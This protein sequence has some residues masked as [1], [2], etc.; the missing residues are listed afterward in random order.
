M[1]NP[2]YE[3]KKRERLSWP[4]LQLL[5]GMPLSTLRWLAARPTP[6]S[7]ARMTF[8]MHLRLKATTGVDFMKWFQDN[9]TVIITTPEET[10]ADLYRGL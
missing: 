3:Y 5:A 9:V 4:Q 8:G 6:S 1:I 2:L 10:E 7:L